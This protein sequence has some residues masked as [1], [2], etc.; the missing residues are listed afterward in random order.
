MMLSELLNRF[1]YDRIF[2][3]PPQAKA[4]LTMGA[5]SS[6]ARPSTSPLVTLAAHPLRPYRLGQ[7]LTA[8]VPTDSL[9]KPR[10][11]VIYLVRRMG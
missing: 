2:L 1:L 4:R 9:Q 6:A 11:A 10:G 7:P 8:F 5:S 3:M